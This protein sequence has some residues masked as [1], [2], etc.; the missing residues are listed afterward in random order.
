MHSESP[1]CGQKDTHTTYLLIHPRTYTWT[2]TY[3]TVHTHRRTMAKITLHTPSLI[4]H[5]VTRADA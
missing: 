5:G 2:Q 3:L 4:I 1:K